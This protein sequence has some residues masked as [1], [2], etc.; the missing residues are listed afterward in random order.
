[1]E[2]MLVAIAHKLKYI[3]LSIGIHPSNVHDYGYAIGSVNISGNTPIILTVDGPSLGGYLCPLTI[4]KSEMWKVGQ[5]R[6][7]DKVCFR[8]V[9]YAYAIKSIHFH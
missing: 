9:D 7:G 8:E 2:G 3:N 5:L 1:M 6:P 4:I